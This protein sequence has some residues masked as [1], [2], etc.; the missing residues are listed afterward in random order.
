MHP[1]SASMTDRPKVI[2]WAAMGAAVLFLCS[3]L[4]IEAL[5][6]Q[7]PFWAAPPSAMTIF[8]VFFATYDRFL[9][10]RPIGPCEEQSRRLPA[11]TDIT[12]LIGSTI[13]GPSTAAAA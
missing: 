13:G 3:G 9:W 8:G 6:W 10:R 5:G 11:A 1:Y 2:A 12:Y 4:G 7:P